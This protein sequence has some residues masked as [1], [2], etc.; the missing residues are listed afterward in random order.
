MD[1]ERCGFSTVK[2]ENNVAEQIPIPGETAP[3]L[4]LETIA[5]GTFDLDADAGEKGTLVVFYRGLHCPICAKQLTEL[6]QKLDQLGELG[7]NVVA[8]SADDGDKAKEMARKAGVENLPIAHSLSLPAARFDWG[9]YISEARP[10]SAEPALFSEPGIFFITPGRKIYG[11]WV[12]STPF[13]RPQIDDLI[14]M[15]RF[16]QAKDYPPRGTYRGGLEASDQ[17]HTSG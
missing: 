15:I 6:E 7:V 9:L 17:D 14:D 12:Q 13:A 3:A 11:A 8:V 4:K 5:N 2:K 1:R 10:D 16:Q